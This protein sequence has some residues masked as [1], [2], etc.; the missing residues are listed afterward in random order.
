MKIAI[1]TAGGT[2]DK[3]YF[4]RKSAFQ[5]GDPEIAKVLEE[6][7]VNFEYTIE[8]VLRKDSLDMTDQDRE[9]VYDKVAASPCERVVVTH[10]TD[11]MILTANK[12]R[13]IPAKVVVLTGAIEPAR[14]RSSDA[15]FNIGCAIAAAQ[16][17][18]HGVYIA[19][20]GRI[21]RPDRVRKNLQL[22]RFEDTGSP[23]LDCHC[24]HQKT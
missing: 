21:F 13:S 2:I 11:T 7:K 18:P 23:S 8:A 9:L 1:I 15:V 22:N 4:D 6:V 12:L 20:N 24:W 19:M 17:L 10:G 5:V 3:V 14:F 16:T